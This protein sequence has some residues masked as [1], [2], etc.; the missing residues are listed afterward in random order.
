M[1][2][3]SF[4]DRL[5]RLPSAGDSSRTARDSDESALSPI[6]ETTPAFLN[7]GSLSQISS[8]TPI[9]YKV[10]KRRFFGLAQLVL[11]NIVVS[12]DWI[13]FAPVSKTS[14]QYFNTKESTINWLSTAFLFAYC[15][16]TPFTF[17]A[18]SK[19]GPKAS[20]IVASC[21]LLV[22]NW[23]RYGAT[24]ANNFAG[25]MVGQLL[26]GLAQPFVLSSPTSY[27]N[28]WFSDAGRTSATAVASLANAFGAALGQLIDPFWA[29]HP[30]QIPNMVLYISIISTIASLPSFFIPTRPPTPPS[31]GAHEHLTST[32]TI[33]KDLHTLFTS[34]EFYLLFIP[35]A[36]YVGFFNSFSSLL[37]QILEPYGY[38]ESDAGIAGALLIVVGLVSAAISSP[39][40]DK[41]KFYLTYTKTTVPIIALAYLIFIWA[42]QSPDHGLAY[43]YVICSILGA[44]SFG[45]VPVVLEFLVEIHHPLGPEVASVAC[46]SGGQLLGGIFIIIQNALKAGPKDTPPLNMKKALIFQAVVALVVMPLPL[47]LGLGGRGGYVRRR[48]WEADTRRGVVEESGET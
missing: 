8:H 7:Q 43:P 26:L 21:L 45:L 30:S 22:G 24:R 14:A 42:P 31:A 4:K 32:K 19:H 41:Y 40:I 13:S 23:I 9:V 38:S 18:L 29:D 10:Y 34:L 37:N 3:S 11:L 48:R 1:G 17:Y 27:S 46:W 28:V 20:I 6:N 47:V 39:I 5:Q 12:W 44:A 25:V 35:F 16:A 15:V 2:L 33:S 36:V